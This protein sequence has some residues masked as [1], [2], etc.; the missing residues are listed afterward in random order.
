ML[1]NTRPRDL[2]RSSLRWGRIG[3]SLIVC[4]LTLGLLTLASLAIGARELSLAEVWQAV[5]APGGAETRAGIIIRELRLPRTLLGLLVGVAPGIAGV[6]M[7]VI[8]RNPLAEPGLLGVN[9]GASLAVVL[10]IAVFGVT[11]ASGWLWFALFGAGLA[12]LVVNWLGM[13]N[14][15][16]EVTHLV[17]AGVAL[18]ASMSAVVGVITMFR[19]DAFDTYRFWMVGALSGADLPTVLGLAPAVTVAVVG[20]LLLAGH[21]NTMALG[22]EVGSGLGVRVTR[23]RLLGLLLITILCGCAVAAAGPIGFVGLVVPHT[24]RLLVGVDQRAV[25]ALSLLVGPI[26]VLAANIIGR[27]VVRPG[28]LEVG[29]V[30][31]FIGAPV[32]LFLILRARSRV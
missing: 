14:A 18:S 32:L 28:E 11:D 20:A 22:D 30:T 8:T 12:A 10:G 16:T 13:R 29:I 27:V 24:V 9:A 15:G 2:G 5:F 4:T 7:Q 25:L 6:V 3:V 21:F 23:V 26:L 17:L 31:A 1:L 19:S